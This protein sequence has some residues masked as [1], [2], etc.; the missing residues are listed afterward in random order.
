LK[1]KG[2]VIKTRKSEVQSLVID[3]AVILGL[4]MAAIVFAANGLNAKIPSLFWPW[5]T[6]T[7]HVRTKNLRFGSMPLSC[8]LRE[9]GASRSEEI[10]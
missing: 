2:T 4:V 9:T 7:H 5:T 6:K 3:I 10:S 1:Q 8:T